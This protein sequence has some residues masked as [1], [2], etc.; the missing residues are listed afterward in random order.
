MTHT[1]CSDPA[2]DAAVRAAEDGRTGPLPTLKEAIAGVTETMSENV[3]G[4]DLE[5]GM[6]QMLISSE[7]RRV[8][9]AAERNAAIR[10]RDAL[11]ARVAELEM[12]Q[13]S[14]AVQIGPCGG[15]AERKCTERDNLAAS[16]GNGQGSLDGSIDARDSIRRDAEQPL[17]PWPEGERNG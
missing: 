14:R 15:S 17:P 9:A 7:N 4:E 11:Q 5:H 8:N 3:I 6:R 2:R 10:E 16:G 13:I 12:A 1:W